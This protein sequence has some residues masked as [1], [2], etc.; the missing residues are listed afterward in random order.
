MLLS[1]IVNMLLCFSYRL[2]YYSMPIYQYICYKLAVLPFKLVASPYRPLF[3]ILLFSSGLHLLCVFVVLNLYN[4][5]CLYITNMFVLWPFSLFQR[6]LYICF[7]MLY[8]I[9]YIISLVFVTLPLSR[10]FCLPLFLLSQIHLFNM[11]SVC[12]L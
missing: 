1:P 5:P 4:T 2:H 9:V 12:I 8:S 10:L 6:R 3:S 7:F 11:F